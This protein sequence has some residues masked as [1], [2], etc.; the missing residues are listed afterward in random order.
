MHKVIRC[1]ACGILI[2]MCLAI[3]CGTNPSNLTP[4]ALNGRLEAGL[5]LTDSGKRDS[6][7][8]RVAEDAASV[9]QADV[10]KK[11][12]SRVTDTGNRDDAAQNC[13]LKL[14]KAGKGS[15]A[16]EV[17]KTITDSGKRD[18]TLGKLAKG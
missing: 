13:A 10:V 4:E 15:E 11:A 14:A 6:A 17:A 12:L 9:G 8:V 1:Q 2:A 18:S 16:A 5:A 3:G 7:L